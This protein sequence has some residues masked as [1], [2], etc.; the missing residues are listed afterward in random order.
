MKQD[1]SA[2]TRGT[3]PVLQ[4]SQRKSSSTVRSSAGVSMTSTTGLRQA[5]AKK[6]VTVARFLCRRSAK[7]RAAGSDEVF[8]VIHASGRISASSWVKIFR[9]SARSSVAASIA[10]SASRATA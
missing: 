9:F 4:N 3:L 1:T 2:V 10:Q 8:E 6:W 5:G 7:I